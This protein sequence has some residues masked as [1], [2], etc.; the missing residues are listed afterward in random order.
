LQTQ[1]AA[2]TVGAGIENLG[3]FVSGDAA[4]K[5]LSLAKK[6]GLAQKVAELT[7]QSPRLA[8][9]VEIGMN[10]LRTGTVSGAQEA[11]HGG[12]LGD[13]ATAATIGAGSS[14]LSEATGELAKAARPGTE[15]IA[16][17]TLKTAPQWTSPAINKGIQETNQPIAQKA[18]GN[19]ARDSADRI[20]SK[21]GQTAPESVVSF[22]DAATT[23]KDAAKPIFQKLDDISGGGY[24]AA[25]NTMDRASKVIR[26]AT[27]MAD[28]QEA[29]KAY[30][31]A[32]KEIDGILTKARAMQTVNAGGSPLSSA[33][34]DNARS[35]WRAMKVQEQLHSYIDA[36]YSM[37]QAAADISGGQRELQ[38]NLLRGKLNSAVRSIPKQDLQTVLG[39]DGV[40]NL[41]DLSELGLNPKKAA[42]LTQ[43]AQQLTQRLGLSAGA[44]MLATHS[45]VGAAAGLP[46]GAGVH[47]LY[48]H[49][50][51]GKVVA[52][53]VS[54]GSS[55]KVIVP[56]VLQALQNNTESAKAE[57]P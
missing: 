46:V 56:A 35:A 19:I 53:L 28:M 57:E 4:L 12:S 34:L 7:E 38:L 27:S 43:V 42:T 47:F 50:Q 5:G 30:N 55:P 36:A 14:G 21:F 20:L 40:K 2:E 33:D 52:Q 1:G 13:V 25:R 22:G 15:Q 45:A 49:P 6:L 54:L 37:P 31:D 26:R 11:A 44:G 10:A 9:A 51:A 24:Q 23:V 32:A 16:G 39:P 18:L 8:K 48:T 3:E 17:E 41:Y 29:D